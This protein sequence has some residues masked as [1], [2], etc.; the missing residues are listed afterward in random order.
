MDSYSRTRF[1]IYHKLTSVKETFDFRMKTNPSTF[2]AVLVKLYYSSAV[3]Y[4]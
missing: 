2:N 1:D 3:C 4:C